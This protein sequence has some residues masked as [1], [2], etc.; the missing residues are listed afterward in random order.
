MKLAEFLLKLTFY[1]VKVTFSSDQY[2]Y[3]ITLDY[4]K[5]KVTREILFSE[6]DPLIL[7]FESL[8]MIIIKER[9]EALSDVLITDKNKDLE[10]MCA[11]YN[12]KHLLE[13]Q[14]D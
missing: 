9:A 11:G 6:M 5:E 3:R 4:K 14:E 1:G 12:I 7:D 10:T 2:V 8:L 13:V